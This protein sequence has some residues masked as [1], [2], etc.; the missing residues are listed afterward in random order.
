MPADLPETPDRPV[1]EGL[2]ALARQVDALLAA[3]HPA[4]IAEDLRRIRAIVHAKLRQLAA[5]APTQARGDPR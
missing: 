4:A 5:D 1:H 3:P 2:R